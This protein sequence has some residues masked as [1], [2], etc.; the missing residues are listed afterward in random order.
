MDK[1]GLGGVRKQL[2]QIKEMVELSFRHSQLFKTIDVKPPRGILLYGPSGTGMI[3]NNRMFFKK[4]KIFILGK[5]LIPRAIDNET[6][7]FLVPIHGSKIMSKS[8]HKSEAELRKAFE[9]AQKVKILL[10]KT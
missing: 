6:R 9:E 5:T 1:S 2:A 3:K 8:P 10:V 4:R 7:A